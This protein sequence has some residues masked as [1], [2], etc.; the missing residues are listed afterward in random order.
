MIKLL[1]LSLDCPFWYFLSAGS[2][3]ELQLDFQSST[4]NMWQGY[5]EKNITKNYSVKYSMTA[6]IEQVLDNKTQ[7]FYLEYWRECWV[8]IFCFH[9]TVHTCSDIVYLSHDW[10][11]IYIFLIIKCLYIFFIFVDFL[12]TNKD[13]IYILKINRY[14]SLYFVSIV[15][16]QSECSS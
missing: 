3:L 14:W 12:Y 1:Y 16:P 7:Y 9:L 13:Y 8:H 6:Q 10:N 15:L 11:R 5:Q 4:D 2:G